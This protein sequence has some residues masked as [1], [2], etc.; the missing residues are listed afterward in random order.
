MDFVDSLFEL[1]RLWILDTI[2]EPGS[3]KFY[4]TAV[5]MWLVAVLSL[6]GMAWV[7]CEWIW[8]TCK[9]IGTLFRGKK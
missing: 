9:F 7:V 5:C 2:G 8:K 1:I 4:L 3:W 6:I